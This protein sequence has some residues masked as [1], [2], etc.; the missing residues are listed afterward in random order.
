M[1]KYY[2]IPEEPTTEVNEDLL[3]NIP[4]EH[5]DTLLRNI[6]RRKEQYV[7]I[8][9]VVI[10]DTLDHGDRIL[11]PSEMELETN[12]IEKAKREVKGYLRMYYMN[13]Q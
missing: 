12:D 5:Q 2:A 10:K 13:K 6:T 7:N 1:K 8:Q 11:Q 3:S 4:L 9:N